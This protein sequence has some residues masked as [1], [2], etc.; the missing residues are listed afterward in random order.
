MKR[1][2]IITQLEMADFPFYDYEGKKE[3]E[4]GGKRWSDKYRNRYNK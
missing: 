3:E 4:K 2:W 1:P